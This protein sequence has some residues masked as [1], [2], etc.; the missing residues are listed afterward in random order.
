MPYYSICEFIFKDIIGVYYSY[1]RMLID[2]EEGVDFQ[3]S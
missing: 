1:N 2:I 3:L